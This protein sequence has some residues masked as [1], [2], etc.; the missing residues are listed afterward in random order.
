MRNPEALLLQFSLNL[1]GM[2]I[3]GPGWFDDIFQV[4]VTLSCQR[5]AI[6]RSYI[7]HEEAPLLRADETLGG[8]IKIIAPPNRSIWTWGINAS[9]MCSISFYESLRTV[10]LEA[11]EIELQGEGYIKGTLEVPFEITIP[12]DMIESYDGEM[13]S[14][15]HGFEVTVSRPWYTFDVVRHEAL[16]IH[17][18]RPA[19][20]EDE[21]PGR[22]H[23]LCVPD[24]GGSCTLDYGKASFNCGD[25]LRGTLTFANIS[26]PITSVRV[27]VYKIERGDDDECETVVRE[28]VI[29]G[30]ATSEAS[31]ATPGGEES[32]PT[33]VVGSVSERR[34][35][36]KADETIEVV[37]PLATPENGEVILAPTYGELAKD[38]EEGISVKYYIRLILTDADG[39][40]FW[41]TNEIFLH[42]SV[43]DGV[44]D[45]EV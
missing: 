8:T 31:A 4:D 36:V 42:R 29:V 12:P 11:Q 34:N 13:F 15:R 21:E 45:V 25:T 35:P 28:D 30:E 14:V 44:V 1:K 26:K 32:A 37:C 5:K 43:L 7:I 16:M 9:L 24:C 40:K 10:D 38:D 23:V 17:R 19:P 2:A 27:L 41:N 18:I 33:A 6:C 20:T 22:P 39:G 3:P